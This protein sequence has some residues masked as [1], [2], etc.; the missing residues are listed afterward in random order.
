MQVFGIERGKAFVQNDDLRV[1]KERTRK[2]YGRAM[3]TR[4]SNS[5]KLVPDVFYRGSETGF[6]HHQTISVNFKE[7]LPHFPA[8]HRAEGKEGNMSENLSQF[9]LKFRYTNN[10]YNL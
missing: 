7:Q 8:R 3:K 5:L 2:V 1:L 6:H 9:R 4:S 10:Q